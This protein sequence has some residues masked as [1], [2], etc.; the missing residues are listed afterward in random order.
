MSNFGLIEETIEL[1]CILLVVTRKS[2]NLNRKSLVEMQTRVHSWSKNETQGMTVIDLGEKVCS[3]PKLHNVVICL[4]T[5]L[6]KPALKYYT[7][8][9]TILRVSR[10][11]LLWPLNGF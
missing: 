4:P 1:S 5:K 9:R 6:T 3:A 2:Y 8:H 10:P 11:I 7:F